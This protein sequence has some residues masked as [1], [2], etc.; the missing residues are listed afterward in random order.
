ML[1]HERHHRVHETIDAFGTLAKFVS[2]SNGS[3]AEDRGLD[4]AYNDYGALH[5]P[6][7]P[8]TIPEYYDY[9]AQVEQCL[10]NTK[11]D[12]GI[13]PWI[14]LDSPS[15]E[16]QQEYQEDGGVYYDYP[17][18]PQQQQYSEEPV[19]VHDHGHDHDHDHGHW[20]QPELNYLNNDY[21]NG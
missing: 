1:G 13:Q 21:S 11:H 20:S 10:R 15:Q 7:Y 17:Y 2:G 9:G 5:P 3:E 12:P 19:H 8:P 6:L 14:N 16:Y 4:T 18:I